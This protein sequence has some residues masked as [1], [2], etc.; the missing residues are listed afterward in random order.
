[1]LSAITFATASPTKRSRAPKNSSRQS[2][3]RV[4]RVAVTRDPSQA[5]PAVVSFVAQEAE[6]TPKNVQTAGERAKLVYAVTLRVHNDGHLKSG[7]PAL[8]RVLVGS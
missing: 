4:A 1:M 6:F 3:G 2:G 8:G 5:I 7:M